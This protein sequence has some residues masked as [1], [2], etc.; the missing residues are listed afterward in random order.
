MSDEA[1]DIDDVRM[2]IEEDEEPTI[3]HGVYAM[4]LLLAKQLTNPVHVKVNGVNYNGKIEFKVNGEFELTADIDGKT[5]CCKGEVPAKYND[6]VAD[7]MRYDLEEESSHSNSESGSES[8]NE[9]N[10]GHYNADECYEEDTH[11][12][13]YVPFI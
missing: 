6:W 11:R 1:F 8:G 4:D 3:A 7:I 9:E 10:S 12:I 5:L 13:K 2:E